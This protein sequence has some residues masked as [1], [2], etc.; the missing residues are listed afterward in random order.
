VAQASAGAR[1]ET[2][3][4]SESYSKHRSHEET[5]DFTW[6]F[7]KKETCMSQ[8]KTL[9]L[10]RLIALVFFT[11]CLTQLAAGQSTQLSDE[12]GTTQALLNEVRSLRQALQ[13]LQRMSFD[14]YRGQLMVE[15][16]RVNREDVRRLAAT[17]YDTRMMLANTQRAIPNSIEEQKLLESQIQLE[18][19]PTKHAQ[20]DFELKRVKNGIEQFKAQVDTLKEREQELATELRTEQTKLDELE[21]RLDLLERAIE[22][23][24]QKLEIDKPAPEKKP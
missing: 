20:L 17:L 12:K 5:R 2:S 18:A 9:H 10:V 1:E 23:D 14:T 3:N 6:M 16:V 19:D 21:S 13:T 8:K 4:T 7:T 11:L 24:R 15:R 22:N